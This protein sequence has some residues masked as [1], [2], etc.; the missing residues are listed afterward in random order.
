MLSVI[1]AECR[2]F[3]DMCHIMFSVIVLNVGLMSLI[4]LSVMVP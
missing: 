3:I 4:M 1:Y 2:I